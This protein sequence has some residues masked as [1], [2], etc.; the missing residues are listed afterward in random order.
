MKMAYYIYLYTRKAIIIKKSQ[1]RAYKL[2]QVVRDTEETNEQ[3]PGRSGV[4][5]TVHGSVSSSA[6]VDRE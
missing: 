1:S 2:K 5:D 3:F 6:P 4:A